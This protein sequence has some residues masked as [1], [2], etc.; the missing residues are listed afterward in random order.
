MYFIGIQKIHNHVTGLNIDNSYRIFEIHKVCQRS[1]SRIYPVFELLVSYICT[2]IATECRNR[3]ENLINRKLSIFYIE[4]MNQLFFQLR[5]K[6]NFFFRDEKKV[7]TQ[8]RCRKL[9][10]FDWCG[11][12]SYSDTLSRYRCKY[13]TP[14]VQKSS[15]FCSCTASRLYVSSKF[16]TKYR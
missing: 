1:R 2:Y 7:G 6:K 10:A 5:R 11:F 12:Q 15:Q 14:K 13:M 4:V 9:I 8:F 16:D 3:S